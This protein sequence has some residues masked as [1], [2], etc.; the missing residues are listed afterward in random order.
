[1]DRLRST[2]TK[3]HL[4]GLAR[5]VDRFARRLVFRAINVLRWAA[6]LPQV[7]PLLEPLLDR[8]DR[9]DRL[10]F[11]QMELLRVA[12]ALD[13]NHLPYWIAG[14]W[15]LDIL[16][17]CET[18]RHGDLDFVL[19]AFHE[20]LP[21]V[22]TMLVGLGYQRKTPLGGTMWFPDA[23]VYEDLDGHHI[24]VLNINWKLLTVAGELLSH[25]SSARQSLVAVDAAIAPQELLS[26][27]TSMGELD[28]VPLPTLSVAAQQLFHLGY[29]PRDEDT[30]ADDVIRLI[31]SEQ[32]EWDSS[33]I[34][35]AKPHDAPAQPTTLLLV[36]IF[37]LPPRLWRLCR[38]YHNDLDLMPPH[39]TL[40]F[41]FLPLAKVNSEVIQRL[42][43]LFEKTAAFDFVLG[44]LRW[45]GSNVVYM[46]PSKS[47]I[48]VSMIEELQSQFPDFH[49]YDG[50]FD[51]VIPHVTLSEHG[52]VA[53]RRTLSRYAPRYLPIAT[54]AAHVW[55]MS[56]ERGL[57]DWSIV[58]IFPLA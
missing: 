30:H 50:E 7:G 26:R 31:T 45:F 23:E 56:N 9:R 51:S 40:A 25:G 21:V 43:T 5:F 41:P 19:D 42:A 57:N 2:L 32:L 3:L 8:V 49:P 13:E 34:V 22:A 27:L 37:S 15:G 47:E 24:E 6:H 18:R 44:Q 14:G 39:V 33:P 58:K 35:G 20:N 38:L 36:P 28:G 55:M 12:S 17:G 29:Q 10:Y 1:M 52:T 4:V 46:E 48:F 11:D 53:D 16:V 54:R